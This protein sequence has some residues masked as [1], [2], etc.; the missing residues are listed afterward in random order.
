MAVASLLAYAGALLS[1]LVGAVVL[2]RDR[3]SSVHQMF[4]VGMAVLAMREV[5]TVIAS[6]A[7]S[8]QELLRWRG[9]A[10]FSE[11]LL[12]GIW[13][14]FSLSF[15]RADYRVLIARWWWAIALTFLVPIALS[16]TAQ[17]QPSSFFLVPL[18]PDRFPVAIIPL[19]LPGYLFYLASLLGSLAILM[20]LERTFRASAGVKRWQIK[21]VVLGVGGVFA[22]Q[23]Y[24]GSQALLFA[25]VDVAPNSITAGSLLVAGLLALLSLGRSRGLDINFYV[26]PMLLH[27]SL[28]ISL[29]GAYLF[30]VGV[31]ARILIRQGAFHALSFISLFVFLAVMALMV[32]LLSIR[33]RHSARRLISR[34][35]RRPAYD[36]RQEWR[37][38]TERTTSL[39]DMP[40]LCGTVAGIVSETFGTS[41]VTIWLLD[42]AQDCF[43]VGGSTALSQ[44][45]VWR[46][47]P[48]GRGDLLH[49]L[50]EQPFPVDLTCP[51]RAHAD[52]P[53]RFIAAG[54][55][56]SFW[57]SCCYAVPLVAGRELLGVMTLNEIR[58]GELFAIEEFDLLKTIADQ[59]A[60]SLLNLRRSEQLVKAKE[61][62]SFQTVSAFFVHDL[63]NLVS[64]LSLLTQNLPGH[65]DDPTFRADALRAMSR[66]VERINRM[67]A[68]LSQISQSLELSKTETDLNDM[69]RTAL[70]EM[71][72][73]LNVPVA[74][75]LQPMPKLVL[76]SRQFQKVLI[77]LLL[78]ANEALEDVKREAVGVKGGA[79]EGVKRETVGVRG[80]E[81][82]GEI[83]VETAMRDGWAVLSVGDTGCGMPKTFMECG[84]FH[85]FRTTKRK[86]LGIGLFHSKRIVEA[87]HG[88]FEVESE[89]GKGS[90]FRVIL[91]AGG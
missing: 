7:G 47:A 20:N 55:A 49:S 1:L 19:G 13:L 60:G 53:E 41:S 91:P 81:G 28:T 37:R 67:L 44:G 80:G 45:Q 18:A 71:N 39:F 36:Y 8:P 4:A 63:K 90:T 74:H 14:L 66:G 58:E 29:V 35:L 10:F 24:T 64:T 88:W 59:T 17:F 68:S 25:S 12:P 82:R 16:I 22:A 86:G 33:V 51:E 77:N 26:S 9:A 78:N 50:L 21:F 75:D 76:D 57:G 54:L 84:L 43:T 6:G 52:W 46:L 61:L 23:I 69:V 11:A 40:R 2:Y 34:H 31:A 3:R 72:G 42:E 48:A 89:E 56:Q 70:S 83:R 32:A 87:H 62:E 15:G 30:I 38:F 5:C 65:F 79:L 27:N 73:L 85:P